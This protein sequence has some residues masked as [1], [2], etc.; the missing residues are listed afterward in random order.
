MTVKILFLII[1]L[2]S[3]GLVMS[4]NLEIIKSTDDIEEGFI[5]VEGGKVWYKILGKN[6]ESDPL[7]I[8]HGGPGASHIYLKPLERLAEDRP[9]IFYDQLGC[10][11]SERPEDV[12]FWT[13]DRFVNELHL[14]R[15]ALGLKE[16]HILGQSW[17]STLAIEY[18]ITKK[19]AGVKSLVLSGPLLSASRW[20]ADQ[21][22]YI[23]QL[24]EQSK[25]TIRHCEENG[26]YGIPEYQE[27]MMEFYQKHVCRLE[28]WPQYLNEA[29]VDINLEQY[30]Y[31]WGPSEF[32]VTGTLK[33][34]ERSDDLKYI[35]IPV[36]FTCGEYDEAAPSTVEYY[37]K[38]LPGS[39]LY[40][41]KDAS[42]EHHIE[43]TAEYLN[44]VG[45]FLQN[46]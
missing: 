34:Y 40:I 13:I 16:L 22:E 33:N 39:K 20:I 26:E 21:Q 19:P 27:A 8:L 24:S 18:M 14:V 11:N 42:H 30:N 4:E 41:L 43:K 7:L 23:E 31:M 38:R 37:Q 25:Q 5:G 2:L 12:S 1:V 10:G 3:G 35:Q 28:I 46:N 36:L 17:G 32:T 44:I 45:E 29:F 6:R 9:V 15:T